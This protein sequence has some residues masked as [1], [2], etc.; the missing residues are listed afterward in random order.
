MRIMIPLIERNVRPAPYRRCV[1]GFC[2]VLRG[3]TLLGAPLA[4]QIALYWDINGS[5][6]EAGGATPSGTWRTSGTSNT[7]WSTNVGGDVATANWTNGNIAVFSAGTDATG[8]YSVTVAGAPT[9]DSI[10]IQR[11]GTIT[12]SSS[13]LNLTGTLPSIDVATGTTAVFDTRLSG[14]NGLVKAGGG[15][16]QLNSTTN[17]Y[18]GDTVIDAG[19]LI[20]GP[21]KNILPGTTAVTV[22]AGATM[23]FSAGGNTSAIAALGGAGHVNIRDNQIRIGDVSSTTFSGVIS[24]G[25]GGGTLRKDG[26]G[27]LTLAGAST[28]SGATSLNAGTLVVANNTAL[29]AASAGNAIAN[30]A[31]LHFS[32]GVA[33]N[34]TNFTLTGAGD[35]TGVLRNLDGANSLTASLTA[36]GAAMTVGSD[37]GTLTLAGDLNLGATNLTIVG[38]GSIVLGGV[39]GGSG[40]TQLV[41]QGT[42][43][44]TLAGNSANTFGG[45]VAIND[46]TLA[47]SKMSGIDAFA[48]NVITIGDGTGAAGSAALTLLAYQQ[49][50]DTAT[51]TLQS[52]GVF[53]LNN[54]SEKIEAIAGAGLISLSTSGYLTVGSL[55]TSS[56]FGGAVSGSGTLVKD[57]TGTLTFTN[58]FSFEGVFELRGGTLA[59]GSGTHLTVGTL[60]ITGS[61]I[62]DFGNSTATFLNAGI[63]TIASGVTLTIQ[64]WAD[65]VDYFH[66]QNFT[67]AILDARG[68]APQNQVT[69]TGFSSN[70]TGWQSYDRQVTPTPEPATYGAL[71][72]SGCLA[73]L[74]Y[75]RF[76]APRR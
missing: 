45:A 1:G 10:V 50:P 47:L 57:G 20:L 52:D 23:E 59:L 21:G 16:L 37:A 65:G 28:F 64:N 73:L 33:V 8:S 63:F 25:G 32:G 36:S 39:V 70:S 27:T 40:A 46:G 56:T 7:N 2:L 6:A 18:T 5:A 24:D 66:T 38:A 74:G 53:N 68:V 49:V 29:G 19:T 17:N 48:S 76:R 26:S 30:G 43:T 71:F 4:A 41:K 11:G 54:F 62:L 72:L 12:F 51:V 34:E 55:G 13:V 31:A 69:F 15:I 75:R 67:G 9:V 58:S 61:T 42:G 14:A 22:G 60:H 44:L 35:G 3:V